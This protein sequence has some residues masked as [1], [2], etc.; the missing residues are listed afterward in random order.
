MTLIRNP[1]TNV[2]FGSGTE[3]P[4]PISVS[5]REEGQDL[6]EDEITGFHS[7][8]LQKISEPLPV[9]ASVNRGRKNPNEHDH[10][11]QARSSPVI[12]SGACDRVVET[13]GLV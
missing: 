8:A 12:L 7:K 11:P 1:T 13:A 10:V 6:V 9:I 3:I 2:I 4:S 5:T